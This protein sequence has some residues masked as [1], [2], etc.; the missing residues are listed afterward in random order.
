MKSRIL[1]SAFVLLVIGVAGLVAWGQRARRSAELYYSGTIEAT[2]SNIA[3]Q[4]SGR[5]QAVLADEG[6]AVQSA[7]IL[8]VLDREELDAQ[9][10]QARAGLQRAEE[11]V[12]QTEVALEINRR[13]LPAEADRAEAAV[14]ALQAQLAQ[15]E[16]GFRVQEVERAR[17]AAESAQAG[18][19][20]SSRR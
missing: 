5:V 17:L 8:A 16:A 10:E 19:S 14:M 15:A 7:E 3:F 9:R 18:R 2:Q 13:V 6:Q 12:K 20:S 4:V 1:L 11:V